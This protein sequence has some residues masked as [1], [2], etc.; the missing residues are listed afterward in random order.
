MSKKALVLTAL[1]VCVVL[2]LPA[3]AGPKTAPAAPAAAAASFVGSGSG[4]F[5]HAWTSYSEKEKRSFLFGLATAVRIMCTDIS[6][7]QKDAKGPAIEANFRE[8][9]NSYA[10]MEPE[11]LIAAMNAL[12]ADSKNAM[13]PLDGAYK[14]SLMQVRGDK[15][16]D[17]IIQSRKYGEGLRK[18]IDQQ[19]QKGGQ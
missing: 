15:V 7:M 14:I 3:Y 12:Y 4:T 19:R 8:C 1:L 2:C 10:G 13:I 18:E 17:I 16:D 5:A 9:F 11:R 6:S